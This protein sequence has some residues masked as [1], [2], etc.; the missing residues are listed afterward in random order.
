MKNVGEWKEVTKD[1]SEYEIL[2][3]VGEIS[4]EAERSWC[5]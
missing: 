5:K 1:V 2:K 3:S 4:P